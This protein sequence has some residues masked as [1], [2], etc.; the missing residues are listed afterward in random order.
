M[1]TAL[2]SLALAALVGSTPAPES[3]GG[4]ASISVEKVPDQVVT[5]KAFE[6]V[7]VVKQHGKTPLSGLKPTLEIKG[8]G[9]TPMDRVAAEPGKEKGQY[10]ATVVLA[11]VGSYFITIHSGFAD[12]RVTLPAITAVAVATQGGTR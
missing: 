1:N 7:F 3:F 2:L 8:A 9:A 6:L 10:K 12:S 11:T 5:G 4:W